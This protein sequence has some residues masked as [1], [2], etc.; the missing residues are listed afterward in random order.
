MEKP[1]NFH[2]ESVEPQSG[3]MVSEERGREGAR[4]RGEAKR[5]RKIFS[6]FLAGFPYELLIWI[7][8]EKSFFW[9]VNFTFAE[10]L[11]K[12]LIDYNKNLTFQGCI[13]I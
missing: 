9:S 3:S 12:Y 8:I 11:N 13:K 5:R 10:I 7:T 4:Q 2:T 6:R 1:G